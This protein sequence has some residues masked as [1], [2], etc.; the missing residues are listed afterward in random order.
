MLFFPLKLQGFGFASDFKRVKLISRPAE[1][2]RSCK[3]LKLRL[4]LSY[5]G[6]LMTGSMPV[7]KEEFECLRILLE[8]NKVSSNSGG[9][10][11]P[12]T[13]QE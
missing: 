3:R 1:P 7:N 5:K 12:L 10:H 13:M 11:M 6:K 9:F 4:K 2:E 8:E